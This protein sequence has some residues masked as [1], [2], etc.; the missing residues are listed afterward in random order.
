MAQLQLRDVLVVLVGDEAL[1]AVPVH[2]GE[3]QLRAR[4]RPLTPADRAG[5]LGPVG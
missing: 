5:A 3:R 1:E 4:V 2:V